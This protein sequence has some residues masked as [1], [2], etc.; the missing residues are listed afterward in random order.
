MNRM[1]EYKRVLEDLERVPESDPVGNARR[2]HRKVRSLYRPLVAAAAVFLV[3]FGMINLSPTVSATFQNVPVLKELVQILTFNPSLRLAVEHDYVQIMDLQQQDQDITARIEYLIVDQK[4]INIFFRLSSDTHESLSATPEILTAD[5]HYLLAGV[6]Y[7]GV[8]EE[9]DELRQITVDFVEDTV[10]EQLRLKLDVYANAA[11]FAEAPVESEDLWDIPEERNG[12]ATFDFL[13]K[14]DP[15]FTAQGRIVDVNQK[16]E[17]DG[18]Q[19]T[20]TDMEIYPTHIRINVKEAETNSAWLTS[21]RFYLELDDGR[22]IEKVSNGISAT[23]STDTPSMVSYRAE[24]S[25]F[26][27]A[28]SIRLIVTGADFLN[29]AEE[30]LHVNLKELTC[31]PLPEHV[32]LHSVKK[33][34]GS[35]LLTFLIK[36][37]GLDHVQLLSHS[38]WSPSGTEYH[39][40]RY[41][42]TM[43]YD[44]DTGEQL[45]GYQEEGYYLD[46]YLQDEVWVKL[47]YSSV[48][49]PQSP[50]VVEL[51]NP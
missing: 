19:I 45:E 6:S 25:F 14:F 28:D 21:L 7:G 51:F 31:D 44:E 1:E 8:F 5:G 11:M 29:K 10:P 47:N 15:L 38:Y 37:D 41:T 33:G 23:G 22:R 50:V 49:T 24:S 27:H 18:Q 20:V 35:T 2:R 34:N 17:I 48:W 30:K 42:S 16:I 36:E 40:N 13:L 9:Q 46:G 32:S 12:L 3:F 43:L 26:Y 39:I 4:Q